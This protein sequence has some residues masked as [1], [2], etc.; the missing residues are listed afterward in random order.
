MT[1]STDFNWA[2]GVPKLQTQIAGDTIIALAARCFLV[3]VALEITSTTY[4][5]A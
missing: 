5:P 1:S 3:F 2:A 4:H